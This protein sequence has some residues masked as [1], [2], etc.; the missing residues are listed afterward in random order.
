MRA[1]IR[2]MDVNT[3]AW[4]KDLRR[5]YQGLIHRPNAPGERA[6]QILVEFPPSMYKEV[7]AV[8]EQTPLNYPGRPCRDIRDVRI[9]GM[10][11]WFRDDLDAPRVRLVPR[12]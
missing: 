3:E 9:L 7:W 6:K 12:A 2:D 1:Y 10:E 4:L 11:V 5:Q 8:W